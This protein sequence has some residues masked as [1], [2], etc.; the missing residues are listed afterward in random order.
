[1]QFHRDAR[2][3]ERVDVAL[4]WVRAALDRRDYLSALVE[5]GALPW[6][7]RDAVT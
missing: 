5:F 2:R 4:V 1:V 6:V 7:L 3:H